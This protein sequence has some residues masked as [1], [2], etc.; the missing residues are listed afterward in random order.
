MKSLSRQRITLF[1]HLDG[2]P[3][4]AGYIYYECLNLISQHPPFY[5]YEI[6]SLNIPLFIEKKCHLKLKFAVAV[7]YCCK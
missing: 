3:D 1:D 6:E 2:L 5:R 4:G 7:L